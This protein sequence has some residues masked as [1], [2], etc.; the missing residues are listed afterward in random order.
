[1]FSLSRRRTMFSLLAIVASMITTAAILLSIPRELVFLAG[2]SIGVLCG[3]LLFCSPFVGRGR[4]SAHWVRLA[5]WLAGPLFL[6]WGLLCLIQR[7]A[8]TKLSPDTEHFLQY[9]AP[10]CGAMGFGILL[11][12]VISGELVRAFS[13]AKK[14]KRGQIT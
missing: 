14:E 8:S 11:L 12:L 2:P 9:M 13:G 4:T 3:L 7:L 1:M 5:F 10:R 6:A